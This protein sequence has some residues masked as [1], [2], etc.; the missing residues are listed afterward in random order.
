[1]SY[2]KYKDEKRITHAPYLSS[3]R[4]FL[5]I[6]YLGSRKRVS[7]RNKYRLGKY[8]R[9][10]VEHL[11]VILKINSRANWIINYLS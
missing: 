10:I 2:K 4:P 3:L 9:N 11:E 6:V 8:Y 5:N 7:C 1:M